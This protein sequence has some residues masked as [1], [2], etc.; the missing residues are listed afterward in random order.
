MPK[1]R[2]SFEFRDNFFAGLLV[3]VPLAAVLWII[4]WLWALLLG[5]S[6]FVP[7]SLHPNILLEI[8]NPLLAQGIDAALT[9]V[10]LALLVAVIWAAGLFSRNYLVGQL[11]ASIRNMFTRVPFL[12][13]V[14]STL[15]QLLKTFTGSSKSFRRVVEIEYPR[16]GIHT[17]ALVTGER[18]NGMVTVFVPT[19]PNPT[20]GF[21][22]IIPATDV[23]AVD[24]TVEEALREIISLGLVHG[25]SSSGEKNG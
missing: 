16:K 22:L 7:D 5:L 10:L 14:Y 15:E 11:L 19:T 18:D 12:S 9:V 3:L 17:L 25:K 6:H 21:Y 20:S 13:T 2:L 4:A 23:R 24:L 8:E 1:R